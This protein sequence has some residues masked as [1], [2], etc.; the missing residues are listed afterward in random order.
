MATPIIS[1]STVFQRM[2]QIRATLSQAIAE[3]NQ[4]H[5]AIR[6]P[7]AQGDKRE[8]TADLCLQLENGMEELDSVMDYFRPRE[9]HSDQALLRIVQVSRG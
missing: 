1:G 8:T 6:I 3:A 5:A 2:A 7:N 4:L 9:E